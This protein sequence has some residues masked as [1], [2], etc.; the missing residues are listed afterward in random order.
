M[1]Y[2]SDAEETKLRE[3]IASKYKD[4]LVEFEV[5]LKTGMRQGEQFAIRWEDVDLE[6]G[7]S[8]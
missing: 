8:G 7:L 2:L 1:R 6:Q 3:V 5:A 4:L